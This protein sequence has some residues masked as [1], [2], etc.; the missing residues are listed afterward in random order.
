MPASAIATRLMSEARPLLPRGYFL[1]YIQAASAIRTITTTQR[2]ELLISVF[3]DMDGILTRHRG[4][5]RLE[6][7][8]VLSRCPGNYFRYVRVLTA[9]GPRRRRKTTPIES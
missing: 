3:L 9:P 1:K 2:D 8:I 5:A 7:W 4:Y 6:L